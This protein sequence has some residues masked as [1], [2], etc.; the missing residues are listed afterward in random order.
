RFRLFNGGRGDGLITVAAQNGRAQDEVIVAVVK[1]EDLD[2][3]LFCT[4]VS[5]GENC[6]NC[7]NSAPANQNRVC[8]GPSCQNCQLKIGSL[9]SGLKRTQSW[10]TVFSQALG[11]CP[12]TNQIR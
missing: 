2:R 3:F 10:R 1:Q 12:D 8:R 7:R 9:L 11:P 6:Q 5:H 4:A